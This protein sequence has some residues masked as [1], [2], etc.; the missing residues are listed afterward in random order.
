MHVLPDA[1]HRG[2]DGIR[3]D[4]RPGPVDQHELRAVGEEAGRPRLVDFDMRVT[5]ADDATH[6]E[7]SAASARLAAVPKH[8]ESPTSVSNRSE[9]TRSSFWLSASPSYAVSRRFDRAM[10]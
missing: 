4:L 6:R 7:D 9:K 8:P 3:R 1:G 2:I 5:V 10:A